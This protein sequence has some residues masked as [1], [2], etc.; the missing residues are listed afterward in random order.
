MRIILLY[1]CIFLIFDCF[2]DI[3]KIKEELK[4]GR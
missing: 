3:R 2:R 4:K 1:I